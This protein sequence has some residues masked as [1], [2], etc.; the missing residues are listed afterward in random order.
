MTH[1]SGLAFVPHLPSLPD[2]ATSYT[3]SLG[4]NF[5]MILESE[6]EIRKIS[7]LI[8][9]P[10]TKGV[11]GSNIYYLKR[12]QNS[13]DSRQILKDYKAILE[14]H[15]DGLLLRA[16]KSDKRKLIA[17]PYGTIIGILLK[18]GREHIS[19]LV[20]S[21]FW[22]LLK[23]GVKMETAR[24]FRARTSEYRI[25]ET[26]LEITTNTGIIAMETNGYTFSGQVHFFN[27]IKILNRLQVIL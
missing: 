17:L 21:P 23:L 26:Q 24:Y 6:K 4:A 27:R 12:C 7:S 18:K 8:G 16:F 5:M 13:G 15:S 14:L 22:I 9:E 1:R 10:L 11:V 25:E 20:L 2:P 19:P 3:Q